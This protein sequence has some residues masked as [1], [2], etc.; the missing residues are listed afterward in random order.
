MSIA[1][2]AGTEAVVATVGE[3]NQVLGPPHGGNGHPPHDAGRL[4]QLITEFRME[5]AGSIHAPVR[6]WYVPL[7]VGMEWVA[8]LFLF[9]AT[10][11]AV[12]ILALLVKLTSSGPAFYSQTRLG[13]Q[14]HPYRIYK[15]RTMTHNCEAATGVVWAAREDPRTTPIGKVL[16]DTHLDELPQLLNVLQGHMSLIGPRPERPELIPA[17]ARAIPAYCH[18]MLVRPGVTGWAQILLPA[19]SDVR[20]VRWKVAHDLHYVKHLGFGMDLRI[21][22]C[23]VCHFSAAAAN[24]CCTLLVGGYGKA[25]EKHFGPGAGPPVNSPAPDPFRVAGSSNGHGAS[26]IE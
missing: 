21:A 6:P 18:R 3:A 22:L 25:V 4:E 19:D 24:A 9:I 23:T 20:G 8:A 2:D 5:A 26:P 10:A 1:S 15:L 11:P 16:R 12:M 17:L 14:G 13:F 7:K